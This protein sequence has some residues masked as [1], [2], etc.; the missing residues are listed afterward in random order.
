MLEEIVKDELLGERVEIVFAAGV[1]PCLICINSGAN[2]FIL[3]F[4]LGTLFNY[5]VNNRRI[6]TAA[7]GGRLRVEALFDAGAAEGIRFCPEATASLMQ[8]RS[9]V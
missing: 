4:L 7:V 5:V 2:I 8:L 1:G 3:N 6:R 9:D